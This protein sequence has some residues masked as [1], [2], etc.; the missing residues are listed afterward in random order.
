M[1]GN[2]CGHA[3]DGDGHTHEFMSET[4]RRARRDG[5]EVSR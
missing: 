3:H 4:E 2:Q 1:S 5:V